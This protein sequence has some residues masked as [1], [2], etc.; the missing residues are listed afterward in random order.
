V[1]E[2]LRIFVNGRPLAVVP[3]TSVAAAI[4]QAGVTRFRRSVAGHPRGPLCGMGICLECRVLIDGQPHSRSCTTP[5]AEGM[6][7]RTD[8]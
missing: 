6:N 8:D 2:R 7:V 5:C 1:N 3:G 4:A